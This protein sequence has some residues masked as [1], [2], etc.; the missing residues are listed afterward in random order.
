MNAC[1][2]NSNAIKTFF[3]EYSKY[4]MLN[5]LLKSKIILSFIFN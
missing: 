1:I 2:Y 4:L 3:L 5:F